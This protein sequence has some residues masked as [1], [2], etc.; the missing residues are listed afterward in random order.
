MLAMPAK[1]SHTIFV[2]NDILYRKY[3][4]FP[5]TEKH[6]IC[7]PDELLPAVI[8]LLHVNHAHS[9]FAETRGIFRHHFFNRND[10]RIIRSF[11]KAC[12]LCTKGPAK[13]GKPLR[14]PGSVLKRTAQQKA[15][16]SQC[17]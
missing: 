2:K 17:D 7:L 5:K 13:Q 8:H 6:V 15:R 12:T 14:Q 1:N 9:A 11:I 3:M 4:N 16:T 10:G